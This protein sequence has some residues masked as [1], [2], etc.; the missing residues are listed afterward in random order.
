M[1]FLS[2]TKLPDKTDTLVADNMYIEMNGE[3]QNENL[4]LLQ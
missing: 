1:S 4:F 2:T 3:E